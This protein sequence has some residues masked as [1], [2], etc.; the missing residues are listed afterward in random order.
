MRCL[1]YST[2]LSEIITV[3]QTGQ[4]H[5]VDRRGVLIQPGGRGPCIVP[6]RQLST[7]NCQSPTHVVPC[8]ATQSKSR[9][10]GGR[11]M[12]ANIDRLWRGV[13]VLN[14]HSD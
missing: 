1:E 13:S 8:D 3:G 10:G 2:E 4:T 14:G 9:G 7:N 6:Q 11:D 5:A 12:P